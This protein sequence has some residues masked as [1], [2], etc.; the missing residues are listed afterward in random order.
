MVFRFPRERPSLTP[1]TNSEHRIARAVDRFDAEGRLNA[2]AIEEI[3]ASLDIPF[4]TSDC[5]FLVQYVLWR[6]DN[7]LS[8]RC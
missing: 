6:L 8:G 4:S 7:P 2:G 5:R 3:V 1:S